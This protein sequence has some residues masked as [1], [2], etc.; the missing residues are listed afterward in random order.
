MQR[1]YILLGM[2]IML[3]GALLTGAFQDIILNSTGPAIKVFA[4]YALMGVGIFALKRSLENVHIAGIGAA[5]GLF[6]VGS[7]LN[8]K[9]FELLSGD[10]LE[11]AKYFGGVAA[12]GL[13]GW[14]SKHSLLGDD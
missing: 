10:P 11:Y 14:I 4:G 2:T 5:I 12:L 6:L 7:I 3:T 9:L 1:K 8:G 13:G